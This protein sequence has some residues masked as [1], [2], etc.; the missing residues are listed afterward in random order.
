MATGSCK[1]ETPE[2]YSTIAGIH[3]LL[4]ML[5][6]VLDLVWNTRLYI[7]G[8]FKTQTILKLFDF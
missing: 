5:W 6:I 1:E 2:S 7:Y 3:F 8:F 4:L